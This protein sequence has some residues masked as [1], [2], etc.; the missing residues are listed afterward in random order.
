MMV[1]ENQT[2][3]EQCDLLVKSIRFFSKNKTYFSIVLQGNDTKPPLFANKIEKI[4]INKNYK[5]FFNCNISNYLIKKV[6][7]YFSPQIWTLGMPCRW[8]VNPKSENCVMIDVD[9]IAC[10]DLSPLYNLNKNVIHGV[11]A[12]NKKIIKK[13]D[14][15]KIGFSE[16]D[17]KNY[18]INFGLIVVP[19][20]YLEKI[21]IELFENYNRMKKLHEY[22]A[23]QLAL[24]YCI[25][26][27]NIKLNLL[28]SKFNYY[29]LMR[30]PGREKIIFIHLLKNKHAYKQ[31][32]IKNEY[33][34][35][36][37]TIKKEI[38]KIYL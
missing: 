15:L 5:N 31:T 2:M 8:F 32:E 24:A 21:G 1:S 38:K 30:F 23:G 27:L 10:N 25:K 34:K 29:D 18:Y 14:W 13:E 22:C 17:I 26:K 19:S 6:E 16:E 28:P 4:D 11:R 12:I 7:F 20:I 3:L 36:V 37:H 9:M 35:L 33:V